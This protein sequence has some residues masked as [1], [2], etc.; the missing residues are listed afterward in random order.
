ME[1]GGYQAPGYDPDSERAY[2]LSLLL[3]PGISAWIVHRIDDGAPMAMGWAPDQEAL[4]DGA[5]AREP[6]TVSFITLPEWS[7]LVP[8]AALAPG[9]EAKHLAL[10]HGGMPSGAMRDE[11]VSSLGATCIY[12]HDDR[13]ERSALQRYP[14]AR[15]LPMQALMVRMALARS[16]EG[17]LVLVHRGT[18]RVDIAVAEKGRLLLS[19]TFPARTTQDLLYFVLLAT[20]RTGFRP[21]AVELQYGGA[22]LGAMDREMLGRYFERCSKSCTNPWGEADGQDSGPMDRWM[23]VLEQFACVS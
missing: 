19:N 18:D 22:Q 16:S 12:V 10:V 20:E 8:D 23:A 9:S 5:I 14:H 1:R 11:P 3:E 15:S 21:E 13:L 2:H 17:P 4:N 7:T 6:V